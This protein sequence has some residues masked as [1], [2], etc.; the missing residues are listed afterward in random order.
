LGSG[1]FEGAEVGLPQEYDEVYHQ[2]VSKGDPRLSSAETGAAL[3]EKLTE[4]CARFAVHLAK[5]T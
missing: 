1:N 5:R 2:G 4:I 3:V